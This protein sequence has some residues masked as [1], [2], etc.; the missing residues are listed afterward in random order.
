MSTLYSACP[1]HHQRRKLGQGPPAQQRGPDDASRG[2][3]VRA[4][5]R[6]WRSARA[7]PWEVGVAD[8]SSHLSGGLS[9]EEEGGY[10]A[11]A[12]GVAALDRVAHAGDDDQGAVRC[13]GGLLLSPFD[14]CGEVAVAVE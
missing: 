9:L 10:G 8:H 13:A 6:P 12:L 5:P 14:R 11:V 7:G 4:G 1:F 2:A 3:K